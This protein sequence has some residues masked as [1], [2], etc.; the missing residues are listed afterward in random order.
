MKKSTKDK[1]TKKT[2]E[3]ITKVETGGEVPPYRDLAK[4]PK[5][6]A[7][8]RGN[9]SAKLLIGRDERSI[10]STVLRWIKENNRTLVA[11]FVSMDYRFKSIPE[12]VKRAKAYMLGAKDVRD[13]S[14]EELAKKSTEELLAIGTTLGCFFKSPTTTKF[15]IDSILSGQKLRS[16][17][18]SA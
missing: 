15:M 3:V 4:I 8:L 14:A 9:E 7:R 12:V 2:R 17:R 13:F 5:L 6:A 18:R 1:A 11:E 10:K 16:M